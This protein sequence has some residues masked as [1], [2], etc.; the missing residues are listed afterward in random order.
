MGSRCLFVLD[1][2][3]LLNQLKI[4]EY[5][6]AGRSSK[7]TYVRVHVSYVQV[8]WIGGK[9]RLNEIQCPSDN[10]DSFDSK[11][12]TNR[13]F[14]FATFSH[15]TVQK[16]LNDEANPISFALATNSSSAGF[17]FHPTSSYRAA[18]L[19]NMRNEW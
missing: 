11:L 5:E 13:A 1:D 12:F 16:N 10:D 8:E 15:D 4:S 9:I 18:D 14:P 17:N 7:L 2:V 6:Y 3:I 19:S